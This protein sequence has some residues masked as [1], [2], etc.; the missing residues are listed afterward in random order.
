M[1]G[2]KAVLVGGDFSPTVGEDA[3]AGLATGS[4][5]AQSHPA[6]MKR[7]HKRLLTLMLAFT[8]VLLAAALLY[9]AGMHHLEG[10]S[11]TFW[12]ALEWASETLSTT[13]YGADAGWKHPLMVMLVVMVQFLGVFL[14]FLIFPVYL[15]PFLEERFQTRLPGDCR[16]LRDHVL[17]FRHGATVFSLLEELK[18]AG[19]TPVI[20]EEDEVEARRVQEAGT[21]VVHG[22]LE[23]RVLERVALTEARALILNDSD[24]RNAATAITARQL[25]FKGSILA[26][27]ETPLHRQ[28]TIL[29]GASAAYT[30][31]HV[32][33][34]ALAARASRKVSPAVAG[35]QKLGRRLVVSETPMPPGCPI[36]GKTLA[37]SR[38]GEDMGVTVIGQ[39]V[40]GR[41]IAPPAPDMRLEP[42]GILILAGSAENTEKFADFCGASAAGRRLGPFV[43]AGNGEV[44]RK[45]AELL[46]DAGEE[47]RIV[48]Q[49]P[50]VGVA[51]VGSVLDAAVL[52][53]VGVRDAQAVILALAE[54]A[55]TLFATV[56]LK[57]HAPHVPVIARVNG[58]E[59]VDR[60]HS[61]GA[62]FA[63]SVSQVTGQILARK[64]LGKQSVALDQSLKIS[65]VSSPELVGKHPADLRIRTRTGC[66]VV[67]IE[68]GR[69]LIVH[70]DREFR[71]QAGDS[72]YI[73]GNEEAIRTFATTFRPGA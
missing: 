57:D 6:F 69:E 61:A 32:L 46:Q 34:A 73:C 3:W 7:S 50:G 52:E 60:I 58:P 35:V 15:I 36:A 31:R 72:V 5:V 30:P 8:A 18:L 1:G 68:R 24:H 25:G 47:T 41:L 4:P 42:G 70:L 63:L 20:I 13:G 66:S 14:V 19:V 22:S 21:R 9:M 56:I 53:A 2:W 23:G 26:L 11:R 48:A 33:G 12:Q 44:G 45:V 38:I 71:F 54:D 67:A 64:L 39:W 28:P 27:I 40:G 49:E 51:V 43:I 29:A 37:E 16:K 62:D 65:M 17:I 55:T 10:K 59:N